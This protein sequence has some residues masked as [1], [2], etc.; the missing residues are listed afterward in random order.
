[1]QTNMRGEDSSSWQPLTKHRLASMS[2]SE[3]FWA[4]LTHTT[5]L[6]LLGSVAHWLS[7]WG[8]LDLKRYYQPMR[9][10]MIVSW[11]VPFWFAGIVWP[12]LIAVG[13][14]SGESLS[15]STM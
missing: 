14:V 8:G 1:M 4:R 9:A 10:T 13:G 2:S 7:S 12:A 3:R 11:A 15:L 5:P 6:K